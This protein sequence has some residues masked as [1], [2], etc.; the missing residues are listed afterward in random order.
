MT[1]N[2]LALG[3]SHHGA[4]RFAEAEAAYRKLLQTQPENAE[5]LHMMGVLALQTGNPTTAVDF[6]AQAIR[7][8]S[9]VSI[10][11]SNLGAALR[12]LG[13]LDEAIAA[14][15][16]AVKLDEN[17]ADAIINLA[18][19]LC[20][21]GLFGEAV[22]L[23]KRVVRLR[24]DA[25]DQYLLL[26][27]AL[28][29]DDKNE[30]AVAVMQ[31]A[32]RRRPRHAP[33]YINMGVA[34]KKLGR[35]DEAVAAYLKAL[36]I[37]PGDTGA[38]NNLGTA[39]QENDENLKAIDCFR[40]A[41]DIRPDYADAWL[42]LSLALRAEGRLDEAIEAARTAVRH[43]PKQAE[44]HTSL[45]FCLLL[46]GA[47]REG[48][49]E[50]E[51][52][53]AMADFSSPRRNFNTPAW[54]GSDPAGKTVLIH[55]EQGIGDAVQFIRYAPLVKKLGAA[56]VVVECNTQLV[57]LL[58]GLSDVDEVVGRFSRM[59][60]HDVHVSLLSLPHLL[61]TELHDIPAA[62]P[63]LRAEPEQVARWRDRLRPPGAGTGLRVGLVWAGN[64]EFRDDRNRSPGLE[65][66]LPLL[67]TP[68][69]RFYALQKGP[70]RRDLPGLQHRLKDNFV[71]LN[72]DINNMA[73][74]AAVMMNLDLVISSC[75]APPHLAGAL[76]RPV[77]TVLPQSCDWRWLSHGDLTPWYPSMRL[78]R[79]EK[80]G[81]WAPV[82]D[83]VRAAL[84]D[85]ARHY[86]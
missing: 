67:E 42:N 15:R 6:I 32:L 55:D 24:P 50:Y 49:A 23:L 18:N 41:L 20:D 11:Y 59:P 57:R 68:N 86:G 54:D 65:A 81:D 82:V 38:L 62:V 78:F 84:E 48:F 56:R 60:D 73:D 58:G 39:Y 45:G 9:D 64:P 40:Q 33:A 36:E 17:F 85:A 75:T 14:G 34:L 5:A 51:W 83:R 29:L 27:R 28:I 70:G 13:R 26:A 66:F 43:N 10:F 63:Y 1:E 69:V 47:L 22:P 8:K 4:G 72:D 61:K 7:R 79:Q 35:F 37:T 31:D 44:G 71:D 76:G 77:W 3:V 25:V 19:A 80:R 30:E 53:S 74:T 16:Q 12:R 2:L 46:K 21:K 52:R